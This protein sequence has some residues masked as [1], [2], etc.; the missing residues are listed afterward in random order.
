MCRVNVSTAG[1]LIMEEFSLTQIEMGRIFGVF[2][3]GYALFQMPAGWLADY[4]GPRKVLLTAAFLWF[5]LTVTPIFISL[6]SPQMLSASF[7]VF[8]IFRALMGI[9]ASPAYPASASGVAL[10][11]PAPFQGRANGII[12]MSIGLG[13]AIT[14]PLVSYTMVEWGWRTAMIISA[15]PALLLALIWKQTPDPAIVR[16]PATAEE[17]V[18]DPASS[19]WSKKFVLLTIS[20][21][22]QGY[23]GYIFVSWFY[24]YLVQERHFS[25]LTGA[26][27]SSMPW[28][29][30]IV[31]IPA[32]GMLSDFLHR[33]TSRA[34]LFPLSAMCLSGVFIAFGARA[35]NAW[36]AAGTLALATAMILCVEGP[37]WTTLIQL[38]PGRTGRAGG[39]M[40]AGSNVGGLLSPVITPVI[41]AAVGWENALLLAAVMAVG[42]G[43]L[44][45]G[46]NRER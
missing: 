45:L 15:M 42:A 4:L 32:G 6:S 17:D 41:A 22:L 12:L 35:E 28:V 5:F 20:Y 9:A 19:L 25:L 24:L 39:I 36:I 18:M 14:P 30:S 46:I 23:V 33:W 38:M 34:Y 40:N 21:T 7:L 10:W 2:L 13:S 44:W 27:M 11:V 3:L 1:A 31:A 26:W 29:L 37:F 43:L 16:Q 8:L